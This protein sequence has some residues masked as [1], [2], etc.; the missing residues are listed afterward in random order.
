MGVQVRFLSNQRR[1]ALVWLAVCG[2]FG[3]SAS[4]C[5]V[6]DRRQIG[7]G[8]GDG[9]T[10]GAIATAW[11]LGGQPAAVGCAATGVVK[12]VVS[13]FGK[14][15]TTAFASASAACSAG[16]LS[17]TG[18]TPIAAVVLQLDGYTAS[19][20]AGK[21]SYGNLAPAGD[22]SITGATTT[23]VSA[24]I[25]MVKLGEGTSTST[26]KGNVYVTWTVLGEAPATACSKRGITQIKV[27]VLDDKRAEIASLT[28]PCK[29][30]NVTVANVPTG[31]R[32]IQLDA[33]GPAAP[34]SWGSINVA[35]PFLIK[36][37]EVTLS[38]KALDIGQRTVFSLDWLF[39]EGGA[40]TKAGVQTVYVEV[41]DAAD[42]VVIPMSDPWAA[43]PCELTNLASYDARV[44]DFGFAQPQCA[45]PPGAHS[46]VVCNVT[47]AAIGL[48]ATG[49]TASNQSVVGGSMLIKP[50]AAGTHTALPVPLLLAP[51]GPNNTCT[52]P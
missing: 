30:G 52:K 25:D 20:V 6:N 29:A 49:V 10:K 48:H 38:G 3:A 8:A 4:G 40:C 13:V 5:V 23:A 21:P 32:L 2:V 27:R 46:L 17:V 11:T 16:K 26:G 51:C 36:N 18:L 33:D 39:A 12:V 35:G 15:Q 31:T 1:V 43:K 37:A 34:A 41:R 14:G 19:D 50:I 9:A 47:G 44:L 28:A 45:I 22:F 42:K 7:A 24:P